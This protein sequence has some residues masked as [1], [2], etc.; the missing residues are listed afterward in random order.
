MP[1]LADT[2]RKS[3]RSHRNHR[4]C[5]CNRVDSRCRGK[6]WRIP[7]R[8]LRSNRLDKNNSRRNSIR[9]WVRRTRGL[10]HNG[11]HK[12][13]WSIGLPRRIFRPGN[14]RKYPHS[15]H[16]RMICPR[17]L[18]DIPHM[19]LL[20]IR[21]LLRRCRIVRYSHRFHRPCLCN[22]ACSI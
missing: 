5:P 21:V 18:A 12:R 20:R 8:A 22:W 10:H 1:V 19:R 11:Y 6:T 2:H 3:R 15:R 14:C 7:S 4:V 16:R 13:L 9:S 17:I